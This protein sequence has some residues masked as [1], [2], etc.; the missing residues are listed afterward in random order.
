[1]DRYLCQADEIR[2][3]KVNN[4]RR[5]LYNENRKAAAVRRHVFRLAV[6]CTYTIIA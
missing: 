5:S 6:S 1:M 3:R 4:P 2:H